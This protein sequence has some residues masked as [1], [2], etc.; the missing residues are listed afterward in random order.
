[1]GFS[2]RSFDVRRLTV[3]SSQVNGEQ[4]GNEA[5]VLSMGIGV[6]GRG[7]LLAN[8]HPLIYRRVATRSSRSLK[9]LTGRARILS[10]SKHS[11]V[12]LS[13]EGPSKSS[14]LPGP[15]RHVHMT[16]PQKAHMSAVRVSLKKLTCRPLRS[17]PVIHSPVPQNAHM[18]GFMRPPY[19]HNGPSKSSGCPS[20]RS[21]LPLKRLTCP[22][23][24][25]SIST[26]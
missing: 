1:M 19:A 13:R 15:G 4:R 2:R 20:I 7:C 23:E 26:A 5:A 16:L 9:K 11:Q 24:I 12:G 18:W 17:W 6:L 14:Q 25:P 8:R 3:T 22:T 21:H 10:P